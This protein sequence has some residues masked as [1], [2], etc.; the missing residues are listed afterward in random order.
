LDS[1]LARGRYGVEEIS[2]KE[3]KKNEEMRK[4]GENL[5]LFEE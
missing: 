3:M 2:G 4:C 5:L 1:G